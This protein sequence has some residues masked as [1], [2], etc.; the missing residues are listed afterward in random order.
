MMPM[1]MG[2]KGPKMQRAENIYRT[3][4]L[5]KIMPHAGTNRITLARFAGRWQSPARRGVR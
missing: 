5:Q 4:M 2:S 1:Q 3:A